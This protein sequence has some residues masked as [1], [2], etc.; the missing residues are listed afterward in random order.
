MNQAGIPPPQA[1]WE[2]GRESGRQVVALGVALTLTAV[3]VDVLLSDRLTFFFDLAFVVTC[4]LVAVSV[5][6]GD[7]YVAAMLPPLVMLT[8]FTFLAL[9]ARD[10]LA[11]ADDSAI[12]AVV[13]GVAHHAGALFAGYA[14][15][16]GWLAW[17]LRRDG[18]LRDELR[19]SGLEA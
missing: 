1:L 16:L 14:L 5:R 4:L 19:S 8:V 10:A 18:A 15:C 9:V 3:A 12:Q 6:R 13:S 17:R 7:F 11:D 2:A